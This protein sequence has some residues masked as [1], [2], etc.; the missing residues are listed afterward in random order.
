MSQKTCNQYIIIYVNF[1]VSKSQLCFLCAIVLTFQ[2]DLH[3]FCL[4]F[5][6]QRA[7]YAFYLPYISW[8]SISLTCSLYLF[9]PVYFQINQLVR[10]ILQ[11]K[12]R[13]WGVGRSNSFHGGTRKGRFNGRQCYGGTE[14]TNKI[15]TI[16][17]ICT[18]VSIFMCSIL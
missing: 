6:S 2:R 8:L 15:Y 5:D 17:S 9:C 11:K 1:E 12:R 7:D 13:N 14:N 16:P 18:G 10:L 3:L 4:K